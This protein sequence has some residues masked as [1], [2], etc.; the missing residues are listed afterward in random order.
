MNS[1]WWDMEEFGSLLI[2]DCTRAFSIF[3]EAS[4]AVKKETLWRDH[5]VTGSAAHHDEATTCPVPSCHSL[6]MGNLWV[7]PPYHLLGKLQLTCG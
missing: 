6:G 7:I 2:T 1:F 4:Q 3:G 5:V